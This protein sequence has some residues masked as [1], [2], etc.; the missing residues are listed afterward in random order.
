[1][2]RS[3][4]IDPS[5]KY[6]PPRLME[7]LEYMK[8]YPLTLVEAPSG[9]GKT[10]ILEHFLGTRLPR[11]VLRERYEFVSGRPREGW[12]QLCAM[13][14]RIDPDCA[15]QLASIGEP[16]EDNITDIAAALSELECPEDTWIWL[17]DF[18]NWGVKCPGALLEA[19]SRHGG[20][21]LHIIVSTQ[22]MPRGCLG[23]R[24]RGGHIWHLREDSFVFRNEDIEGYF[25]AAGVVLR[26]GQVEELGRLSEGWIMALSLQLASFIVSGSFHHGGMD[27][28]MEN[29]FWR[30]LSPSEQSFLLEVSIFP[31]FTLAQAVSFSG[32]GAEETER[33]LL[34]RRYFVNYDPD[35]RCFYLHA[36]LRRLLERHFAHLDAARQREIYLRG[37]ELAERAKDRLLTLRFY[38]AS[39]A[40]ERLYS[41]PLTSYDIAD[42]TDEDTRPIILDLLENAPPEL[43]RRYPRALIPLAFALFFLGE[44]EKLLSMQAEIADCI[45]ESQLPQTD[46][47]ALRGE[48]E[49]LLSFLE[50]NRIDAMSA[51]HRRALEL[52]GGPARLISVRSTWTFGSP[53]VLYMFWRESGK[54]DEELS[55][56]DECMPWYYRLT[57]GHGSGAEAVMRAEAHF[58]RG[59]LDEAE[60]LCHRALFTAELKRQSS[61]CQ[62]VFFLLCRIAVQRGDAAL[63]EEARQSL[64]DRAAENTED[65]CRYTLDLAEGSLSVL[66]GRPADVPAWLAEGRIDQR[67]VIMTQPYA[68]I[69]YGRVLLEQRAYRKLLGTSEYFLGLSSI[70]PNLLPQVYARLYMAQALNALGRRE[71]ACREVATALDIAAPDRVYMPFAENYP[72]IRPLLP[73][74]AALEPHR[75]EIARLYREWESHGYGAPAPFTPRERDI[76]HYLRQGLTNKEIAQRLYL[77]PHTVR[78]T[79]SVMLK[80]R[81]LASREQL[82]ELPED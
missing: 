22:P 21:R 57:G 60:R 27:E 56:M 81:S 76:L 50:Y 62:C 40:W 26:R 2:S 53:S 82:R 69:V 77:S 15:R 67:L 80:K 5:V 16:D 52:L 44:N 66:L 17:D 35:N 14:E 29:V 38:Y 75:G 68:Y 8:R 10:T 65:L 32:L 73:L 28:L 61:I 49:L 55:Q 78:N 36:Q 34:D 70:F 20:E 18:M 46:K 51:R 7:R 47:D 37:G 58:Q 1:M 33:M 12:R 24:V 6:Y 30:R 54:L 63:L 9:F 4:Q 42:I 45:S 64:R 25:R 19:L 23:G 41:M 13:L 31:R 72:G 79:V 48:M 3:R 71:E 11:S 59:E 39:V 43:K 74:S